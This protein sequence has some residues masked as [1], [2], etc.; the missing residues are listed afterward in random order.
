MGW[1][2]MAAG[3]HAAVEDRRKEAVAVRLNSMMMQRGERPQAG[4]IYISGK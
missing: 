3:F 1:L 4:K 2:S